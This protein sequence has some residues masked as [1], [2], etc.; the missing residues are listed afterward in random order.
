MR[1]VGLDSLRLIDASFDDVDGAV[2]LVTSLADPFLDKYISVHF[3]TYHEAGAVLARAITSLEG[4]TAA[5]RRRTAATTGPA[6]FEHF[7]RL[8]QDAPALPHPALAGDVASAWVKQTAWRTTRQRAIAAADGATARAD[9]ETAEHRK[10]ADAVAGIIIDAALPAAT[11]ASV[12]RDPQRA[13]RRACGSRRAATLRMR[14]RHWVRFRT[15]VVAVTGRSWPSHPS[16]IIEY[17]EELADDITC[18]VS[19]P[20]QLLTALNFFEKVGGVPVASRMGSAPLV[21]GTVAAITAQLQVS[22]P[23]PRKAPPF[24]IS[25]IIA[26]EH[27]VVSGA[28]VFHRAIAWIRL[29]KVWSSMRSDDVTGIDINTL[30]LDSEGFSATLS[31]TKVSGPGRAVR[32]LPIFVSL[33]A[34]LADADWLKTGFLLW[35]SPAFGFE[36]DYFVPGPSADFQSVVKRMANASEMAAYGY[37]VLASLRCSPDVHG[38]DAPLLE[39]G[40]HAFWTGHSERAW[41]P[42]AAAY[43]GYARAD[44][45]LLGRWLSGS[46]GGSAGYIR[47]T[48][49]VI[50]GIQTA[51]AARAKTTPNEL[52]YPD[53]VAAFTK[54]LRTIGVHPDTVHEIVA[55]VTAV[56]SPRLV[57]PSSSSPSTSTPLLRPGLPSPPSPPTHAPSPPRIHTPSTPFWISE[58]AKKHTKRLHRVG[59]CYMKPGIH[60]KIWYEAATDNPTNVDTL[61]RL[62]F[63]KRGAS[64]AN[65]ASA[66]SAKPPSSVS[67]SDE[68]SSSGETV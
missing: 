10:W 5:M 29:I 34:F 42:S 12:L 44:I 27:F 35:T 14:V 32:W 9:A 59:G 39:H 47:S 62:C 21:T 3:G 7:A 22:Q 55:K 8:A 64:S 63:K 51:I 50:S 18:S 23:P 16:L 67:S 13:L 52:N 25:V 56:P 68:S 11:D 17:L 2:E 41:L 66:S 1:A 48:R 24:F 45:D 53:I 26:L 38:C 20:S 19:L 57:T 49:Q 31:R 54:K 37:S 30:V 4:R 33:N 6:V 65:P 28:P 58:T 61:C 40:A 43:M 46:C 36:R 60:V 15:W